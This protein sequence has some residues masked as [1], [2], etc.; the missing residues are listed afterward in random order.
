MSKACDE[1]DEYQTNWKFAMKKANEILDKGSIEDV[2]NI[3]ER[4]AYLQEKNNRTDWNVRGWWS[5]LRKKIAGEPEVD[6]AMKVAE[7]CNFIKIDRFT[8]P[9]MIE[10]SG[11]YENASP[12]D[13]PIIVW[14]WRKTSILNKVETKEEM[15]A[16]V[17]EFLSKY[18]IEHYWKERFHPKEFGSGFLGDLI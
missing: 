7:C 1:N 8:E 11:R 4:V 18:N 3:V 13:A 14:I 9:V 16:I 6:F 5:G 17:I 12:D 10:V 2:W 15:K